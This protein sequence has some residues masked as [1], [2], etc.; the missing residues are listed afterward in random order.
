MRQKQAKSQSAKETRG[1]GVE[2]G[3]RTEK[4]THTE[5]GDLL[6]GGDEIIDYWT[7]GCRWESDEGTNE[8]T[9]KD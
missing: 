8:R 4:E 2:R 6:R 9:N 5:K 1:G 7:Y 3:R